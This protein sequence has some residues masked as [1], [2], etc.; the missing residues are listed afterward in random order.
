ML[1]LVTLQ[2]VRTQFRMISTRLPQN[3]QLNGPAPPSCRTGNTVFLPPRTHFSRLLNLPRARGLTRTLGKTVGTVTRCGPSLS[4]I[5]PRNCNSLPGSILHRLLQL[6]RPLTVTNSTCNLV[7]RCFVNRFTS[8][9]VRGN[10]RCFAP[11]DVI[12]LVIRIVRPFRKHVLS[13]TYNSNNVFIRSTR[14]IGQRGRGP[15]HTVGICNIRGVTS[16]RGLYQLGLTIRNLSNSVHITDDC[17]RSPRRVINGFS[18]IVTGPPFGRGRISVTHL[19][20]RTKRISTHFSLKI[21]N[22][23]GTGC[24]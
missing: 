6:L 9:F 16:A 17:C 10:N 11:S 18:F 7:F 15:T 19:V 13:P 12:G 8:T 3:K 2:R 14:F 23:G 21:P 5:L 4:N 24:L 1:T 20:G 22:I